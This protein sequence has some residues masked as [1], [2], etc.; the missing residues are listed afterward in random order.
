MLHERLEVIMKMIAENG[1][2][3]AADLTK[4][5]GMSIETVRRDLELLEGKGLLKRVYGG[6]ISNDSRGIERIYTRRDCYHID[7]KKAIAKRT[8]EMINDGE[9]IIIDLGTTTLEV[10]KCLSDK[11]HLTI[12]TNSLHVGMEV[13]KNKSFHV[14]MLGGELRNG[15]FST[16]G[17]LTGNSLKHFHVDKAILGASGVSEKNGVTD[18][19]VEEANARRSMIDSAEQ[20][21]LCV[22][23][24]KFGLSALV[25][26]C[27]LSRINTVVTDWKVGT[28]VVNLFESLNTRLEVSS[29]LKR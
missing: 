12:L 26:V 14:Y 6:A 2:V 28:S 18:Y 20:N 11:K 4:Q 29:S 7:E 24:S 5:F 10:A 3:K 19:H 8:A 16:S 15:D 1:M 17:F 9:A 27:E 23:S 22:D 25:Q 21:I 13:V